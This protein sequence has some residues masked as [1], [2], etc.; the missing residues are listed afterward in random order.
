MTKLTSTAVAIPALPP[1]CESPPSLSRVSARGKFLWA[2]SEKFYIHGVTYG[3]FH[4]NPDDNC[5][6]SA[7]IVE[8]DFAQSA[9]N[10]MNAIRTYDVP[11]RWLLDIAQNHNLRVMVGLQVEQLASFLDDHEVARDIKQQVRSK[12]RA[13]AGHPALLAYVIANEIPASIVRWH[14]PRRVERFLEDL[15]SIAK[16]EDPDGL[17][18]Y[19]NYPTTEY[20]NLQF[21]DLACY[22]VYL[23]SQSSFEAYLA[24]LETLAGNRPL[25]MTELGLDSRGNGP[26]QQAETLGW[27]IR[28]TFAA[29]CAGAFVFAWTDD[30]YS[31]GEDVKDWEFGLTDRGRRPKLALTAVRNAF[32][33]VPFAPDSLWPRI[34]VVVCTFNGQRTIRDCLDGLC[35]LRYPDYEVIVV[36]DGSTDK[37]AAIAREYDFR[38]ISTENRGLSA[39]RNTGLAAATGEI[40]AYIDDDAFPDPDWLSYMAATFLKTRCAGVGGPN[41]PFPEDGPIASCVAKAPG[42]PA[43]VL[44]ADTEAEHLAG[45]NMA[46]RKSWLEAIGGF[47]PQFRVAGD[48][49]AVAV[50]PQGDV[51]RGMARSMEPLPSRHAR[52]ADVLG[53]RLQ[54]WLE[55]YGPSWEERREQR[56]NAAFYPRIGRRIGL[57]AVKIGTFVGMGVDG[58]SH[59]SNSVAAAPT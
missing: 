5:Y 22:N 39:A 27:Q 8:S 48:Q 20:L 37:T 43:C 42:G 57:R 32:R 2:G 3:P 52:H 7:Q 29:G 55:I 26:I 34:S 44:L 56:H 50:P 58:Q 14:G 30:W 33:E 12:V 31:R 13:C 59:F 40:V 10:G 51:A 46:F 28:A 38:I 19:A 18:C 25:L 41:I 6:P 24:R 15:Y 53:K 54:S 21:L 45:C 47:D 17:F 23:E 36:D 49:G 35:K 1:T 4:P 16:C 9:A 11:P